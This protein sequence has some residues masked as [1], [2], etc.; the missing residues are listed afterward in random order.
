M[1]KNK[2]LAKQKVLFREVKLYPSI[3]C[4]YSVKY[5]TGNILRCQF[6]G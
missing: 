6:H 4:M 1:Q 5:V 3:V 2:V